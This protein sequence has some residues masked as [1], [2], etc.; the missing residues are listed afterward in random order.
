[1]KKPTRCIYKGKMYNSLYEAK[2]CGIRNALPID[3]NVHI[4]YNN[5]KE[6]LDV[7]SYIVN[8]YKDLIFAVQVEQRCIT[9]KNL[10]SP[11][12]LFGGSLIFRVH[13]MTIFDE[14]REIVCNTLNVNDMLL[15][16]LKK[17]IGMEE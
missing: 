15:D 7:F 13:R 16:T 5:T 9:W 8:T 10:D 17:R 2:K 4:G 3:K 12:H 6:M 14:G 11:L 1:M